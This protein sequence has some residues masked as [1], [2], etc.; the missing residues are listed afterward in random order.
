MGKTS[1]PLNILVHPSLAS[2]GEVK[3]LRD[4][5]HTVTIGEELDAWDLILCPAC[6]R[7]VSELLKYLDAAVKGAR[8]VR[9]PQ[10]EKKLK[11]VPAPQTDLE[12]WDTDSPTYE[13]G[14]WN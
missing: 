8:V 6:F 10:A 13:D 11:Q 7:M 1:K 12:E 9:Y 5:G 2:A 4:K 3:A 14:E